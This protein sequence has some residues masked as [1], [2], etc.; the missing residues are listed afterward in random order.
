MVKR[1]FRRRVSAPQLQ[2]QL[3][4]PQS[5]IRSQIKDNTPSPHWPGTMPSFSKIVHGAQTIY[6]GHRVLDY[7]ASR[8]HPQRLLRQIRLP[9]TS[10]QP[11]KNASCLLST[12]DVFCAVETWKRDARTYLRGCR[13]LR[14]GHWTKRRTDFKHIEPGDRPQRELPRSS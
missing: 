3:P 1:N 4:V 12:E 13:L 8:R 6:P 7:Y 5:K 2:P 10:L 14:C 11:T 9:T